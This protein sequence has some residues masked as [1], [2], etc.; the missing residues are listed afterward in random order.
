[1]VPVG[2]VSVAASLAVLLWYFRRSIPRSYDASQLGSMCRGHIARRPHAILRTREGASV[3]IG[4]QGGSVDLVM[5]VRTSDGRWLCDDDSGGNR[6]PLVTAALLIRL[7]WM[8]WLRWLGE[9]SIV[10]YL[11]FSIPMAASRTMRKAG[12]FMPG[13][14]CLRAPVAESR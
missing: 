14:I 9:H 11:S 6:M 10:V 13:V 4:A 12:V 8:G 7:P 5:A 3:R 2:L 1:M